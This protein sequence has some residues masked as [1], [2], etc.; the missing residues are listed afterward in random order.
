MK[1]GG[2]ILEKHSSNQRSRRKLMI[3]FIVL[4]VIILISFQ[5]G[6]YPIS[7]KMLFRSLFAII[8]NNTDTI[9][10]EVLTVLLKIRVPRIISAILI[11]A[12]LSMSGSSYQALFQNPMVSPDI[13][14]ASQGAGFGA[15]LGLL[16]YVSYQGTALMA[17]AAGLSAVFIAYMISTK[18]KVDRIL[19]L[20]LSGMMVGSIFSSM[21]SFIKLVADPDNTLPA[22][23]YWLM[24]SLASIRNSDVKM[25]IIP[26]TIGI[27]LTLSIRWK[28]NL[29]TM[30]EEEARSM[31]VNTKMTRIII[32]FA[33][34]LMTAACVSVSG[35]I[36][37]VG[38]VIPHFARMVVGNDYRYVLP[39]S[40]L[41][42][43]SFLLIVDNLARNLTTAEIPLGILTS[44]VGAPLFI[45]LILK[46]GYD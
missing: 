40:G 16:W 14:G 25:V 41:I 21:I 30:G 5:L 29:L 27:V 2:R 24:G 18:F 19:G 34:T 38:L 43:A 31:G 6:R 3:L 42:G 45:Y 11:G 35:M 10:K 46:R 28:M 20:V 32:V 9:P 33:S 7:P 8:T 26:I 37:W 13:L 36:G 4:I 23:T 17:F 1:K 15:A 44:F 22:I 39:A 12:A